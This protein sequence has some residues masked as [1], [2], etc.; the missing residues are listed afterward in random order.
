LS[1]NAPEAFEIYWAAIRSGL[2]VTFVNW[3]LSGTRRR[4]SFET[5]AH[6]CSSASGGV[7]ALASEVAELIP[8]VESRYAFGAAID[9]YGSY[10]DLVQQAGPRL[11][12]QP[13]GSGDAIRPA[14]SPVVDWDST[15]AVADPRSTRGVPHASLEHL[16]E[17]RVDRS[18][19]GPACCTRSTYEPCRLDRRTERVPTFDFGYSFGDF[20][21]SAATP[22]EA[23]HRAPLSR[24]MYA[25]SS[26]DRGQFHEA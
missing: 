20:G 12:D 22:P 17:P 21:A 7:A 16:T 25:A 10:V 1:D 5:V 2:Y 3:H 9:G 8:D 24:T 11:T 4:T 13:R 26:P 23:R 6:G 14:I 19:R 15:A 18:V